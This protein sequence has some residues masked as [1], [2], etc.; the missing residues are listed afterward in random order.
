MKIVLKFGGVCFIKEKRKVYIKFVHASL[1]AL[2]ILKIFHRRP[3]ES[4]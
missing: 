2:L 1:K 4:R 3:P